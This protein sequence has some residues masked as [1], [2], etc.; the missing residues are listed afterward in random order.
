MSTTYRFVFDAA[1]KARMPNLDQE[2]LTLASDLPIP[3]T[4][5]G[6]TFAALPP[7]VFLVKERLFGYD[8]SGGA[9]IT[10]TVSIESER[11]V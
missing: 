1:A 7:H 6:V 8:E 5:D 3:S 10:F 9:S 4:G 2:S 11:S